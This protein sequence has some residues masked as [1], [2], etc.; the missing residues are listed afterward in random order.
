MIEDTEAFIKEVTQPKLIEFLDDIQLY[1]ADDLEGLW[2]QIMDAL[3]V[4]ELPPPFWAF[5]WAGGLGLARYILDHPAIVEG[6]RVLDFASGSGLVAIAASKSKSKKLRVCDID[7]LAK[8]V[9][10]LNAQLNDARFKQIDAIDLTQPCKGYDVILAGD[11]CYEPVTAHRIIKWLRLC[12]AQGTEVYMGDP[13]RAY[14]PTEA[15]KVLAE[16][17]VPTCKA[18][19]YV[20]SRNVQILKILSL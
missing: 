5:A 19:E 8:R 17:V 6:K 1:Q 7:P 20:S 10:E 15:M 12:A 13:G 11:V 3:G 2:Q 16:Y 9:M 14:M 4:S 18:T